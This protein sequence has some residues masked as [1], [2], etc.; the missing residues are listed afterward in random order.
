[1]AAVSSFSGAQGAKGSNQVLHLNCRR[2]KH[3]LSSQIAPPPAIL[4][5]M[6]I[7]G[8]AA[9]RSYPPAR[10]GSASAA[11]TQSRS[12]LHA[13]GW[14][15]C[16]SPPAPLS[17]FCSAHH[18]QAAGLLRMRTVR[19]CT[20]SSGARSEQIAPCG[21]CCS[22][23]ACG[24]AGSPTPRAWTPA[25]HCRS[26]MRP[27]WLGILL[28]A[29]SSCTRGRRMLSR[30]PT[31]STSSPYRFSRHRGHQYSVHWVHFAF[32]STVF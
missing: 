15:G 19:C 13:T 7:C 1:M 3:A 6:R 26:Q 28:M 30:S 25:G 12:P 8:R 21:S 16:R 14:P 20:A 2:L 4:P 22:C 5:G 32:V 24:S 10:A 11:R 17:A 27:L 31:F 18:R 9:S 23:T 29:M